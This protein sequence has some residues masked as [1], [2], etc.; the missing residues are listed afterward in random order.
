MPY[1]SGQWLLTI[2]IY[3]WT[4]NTLGQ[5]LRKLMHTEIL[6]AESYFVSH[7]LLIFSSQ[8]ILYT[9][10]HT[11]WIC[12]KGSSIHIQTW[13]SYVVNINTAVNLKLSPSIILYW[14][15][16][17]T[18]CQ[19]NSFYISYVISCLIGCVWKTPFHKSIHI[20]LLAYLARS[21]EGYL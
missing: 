20:I 21:Q 2:C 1:L 11:D 13:K 5:P 10:W 3:E 18:K 8:I 19:V 17:L 14:Y 15:L 12:E 9:V 4:L 6:F 16:L 7:I